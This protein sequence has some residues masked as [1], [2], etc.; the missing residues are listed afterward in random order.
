MKDFWYDH[1]IETLLAKYP[2]K[3]QLTQALTDLLC[4]E[5]EAVYRRL[6][7][8]VAFPIHEIVKIAAAWNISLDTII[9]VNPGQISFR[10]QTTNYLEPSEIEMDNLNRRVKRLEHLKSDPDSEYLVVSNNLSRTLTSGFESLYKL[11][12]FK[13]KYEYGG[14]EGTPLHYSQT[15]IPQEVSDVA[16]RYYRLMKTV[17]NTSFILDQMLFE[18]LIRDIKY[19]QSI[20]LITEKEKDIIKKE[21]HELLDYLLDVANKGYYPE[22]KKKVSIYISKV[23]INT[24]YSYFYTE[25]LKLCRVHAFNKYDIYTFDTEMLDYFRAWMQLKKRTSIQ[26][27]EVDEKSRIDFFMKQHQLVNSL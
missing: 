27:S 16:L 1:F 10:M 12:I 13:W 18:Y 23:N 7:K 3:T 4:I 2:K 21:L 9:G 14:T 26:I 6:R 8:D 25:K 11:N 20:L 17:G 5:R 24:N 22:T 15:V 19:F